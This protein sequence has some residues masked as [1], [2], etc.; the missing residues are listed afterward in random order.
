M[1]FP[2]YGKRAQ[3]NKALASKL[4]GVRRAD[5]KIVRY[6]QPFMPGESRAHRH[7]FTVLQDLSN[8]D[9]HRTIQPV[10]AV[11]ERVNFTP[12]EPV[13]CT[14]TRVS[15][16]GFNGVLTPGAEI[17]RFYVRKTGRIQPSTSYH[18]SLSFRP[19]TTS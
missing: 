11:S 9:K 15:L 3:Y 19:S 10:V 16:E 6:Y 5:R 4:P 13:D 17:A 7:V 14:V 18:S 1:G 2:I 8:E 12:A